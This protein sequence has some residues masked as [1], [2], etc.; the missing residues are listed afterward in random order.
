MRPRLSSPDFTL[1]HRWSR[2]HD[3]S[4]R[5]SAKA[6]AVPSEEK[7]IH[8]AFRSKPFVSSAPPPLANTHAKLSLS[9]AHEKGAH[10][11]DGASSIAELIAL[12]CRAVPARL[13]R[14]KHGCCHC[15]RSACSAGPSPVLRSSQ[16][17][18]HSCT[19]GAGTFEFDSSSCLVA[20]ATAWSEEVCTPHMI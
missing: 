6:E 12:V 18:R 20:S 4:R 3:A 1:L 19:R 11:V 13:S 8:M 9:G 15:R 16:T 10:P 5:L 7:W 14:S 17:A 2:T